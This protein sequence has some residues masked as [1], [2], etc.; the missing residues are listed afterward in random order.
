MRRQLVRRVD[1]TGYSL[2][3]VRLANGTALEL[4]FPAA[5]A[6]GALAATKR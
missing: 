2:A 5:A 6:A 1:G 3:D 4:S